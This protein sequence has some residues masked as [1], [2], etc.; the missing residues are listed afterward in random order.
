MLSASKF[1]PPFYI[2]LWCPMAVIQT[3]ET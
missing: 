1:T 2:T 3:N